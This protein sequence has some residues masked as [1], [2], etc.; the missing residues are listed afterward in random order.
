MLI[1]EQMKNVFGKIINWYQGVFAECAAQKHQVLDLD[2]QHAAQLFLV[3]ES[4]SRAGNL[5]EEEMANHVKILKDL[6]RSLRC[7]RLGKGHCKIDGFRNKLDDAT[8]PIF[9]KI[10]AANEQK[11][12]DLVENHN[13]SVEKYLTSLDESIQPLEPQEEKKP[14]STPPKGGAFE[15]TPEKPKAPEASPPAID[16][17]ISLHTTPSLGAQSIRVHALL[18]SAGSITTSTLS[19]KTRMAKLK[20]AARTT[21][22]AYKLAKPME[23]NILAARCQFYRGLVAVRRG[24][25]TDAL[26]FFEDAQEASETY[27]EYK[28]ASAYMEMC[29]EVAA[30]KA[31]TNSGSTGSTPLGTPSKPG[32]KIS[33]PFLPTP[34]ISDEKTAFKT[35]PFK[36]PIPKIKYHTPEK[37]PSAGPHG[38][39][40]HQTPP[41]S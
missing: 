12:E 5:R 32:K 8:R 38:A 29:E 15:R 30:E 2:R 37:D 33:D 20:L 23:N 17:L 13:A 40:N 36:G 27:P 35:P 39:E 28:H 34:P 3:E 9:D 25:L 6:R 31:S 22:Q 16:P 21:Y 10:I 41:D 7:S 24:K 14:E 26:N 18:L 4:K 1:D 19:D 11:M